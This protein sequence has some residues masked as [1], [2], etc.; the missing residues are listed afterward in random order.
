MF[1]VH[2]KG[3]QNVLHSS[4]QIISN[5]PLL[6]CSFDIMDSF[7]LEEEYD[8]VHELGSGSY[9]TVW[10]WKRKRKLKTENNK[11]RYVAVKSVVHTSDVCLT[12]TGHREQY[13]LKAAQSGCQNII[14]YYGSFHDSSVTTDQ[15]VLV[16]EACH[17]DLRRLIV[18]QRDL[19]DDELRYLGKQILN[20]LHHL[21]GL[22][23]SSRILHR[24]RFWLIFLDYS[25]NNLICFH[26]TISR[27]LKPENILIYIPHAVNL[28]KAKAI[29]WSKVQVNDIVLKISDYGLGRSMR[30]DGTSEVSLT[31]GVGTEGYIAPEVSDG[32]YDHSADVWSFAVIMHELTVKEKPKKRGIVKKSKDMIILYSFENVACYLGFLSSLTLSS[33]I[34]LSSKIKSPVL[35]DFLSK[36]LKYDLKER[37]SAE[38]LL[39]HKFI[40]GPSTESKELHGTIE[41]LIVTRRIFT[42]CE[43]RNIFLKLFLLMPLISKHR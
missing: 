8:K 22:D 33:K 35:R 21:H 31:R 26:I 16:M 29:N 7:P 40:K 17:G 2:L 43:I 9:G 15:T 18:S 23:S 3:P 38:E 6:K 30:A 42:S 13:I 32:K 4:F 11:P 12:N 41:D 27:D 36:G 19:Q 24:F 5:S 1:E 14:N 39:T 20:G 37:W 10:L 25:K 28:E 34:A